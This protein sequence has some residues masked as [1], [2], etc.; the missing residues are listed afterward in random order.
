MQVCMGVC[1]LEKR[2]RETKHETEKQRENERVPNTTQHYWKRRK[3]LGSKCRNQQEL[4]M[5]ICIW[6]HVFLWLN[7][8]MY[9]IKC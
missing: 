6:I 4:H 5:Y 2:K 9:Y 8:R 7:I 1:L 3:G